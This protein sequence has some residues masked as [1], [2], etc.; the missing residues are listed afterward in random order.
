MKA[1][2]MMLAMLPMIFAEGDESASK[3]LRGAEAQ[4][5]LLAP[6]LACQIKVM[7]YQNNMCT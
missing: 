6:T 4:V 1:S 2:F 7:L 5:Q 3:A